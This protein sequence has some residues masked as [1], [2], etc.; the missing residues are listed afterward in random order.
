MEKV[1][2]LF[3]EERIDIGLNWQLSEQCRVVQPKFHLARHVSTRLDTFNV[4]LTC[5]VRAFWL[6]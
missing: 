4:S 5:R 6:C 3:V 2:M 1:W